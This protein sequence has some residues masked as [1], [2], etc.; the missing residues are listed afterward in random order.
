MSSIITYDG[1]H[2]NNIEDKVIAHCISDIETN[3]VY[4]ND[5]L[6]LLFTKLNNDVINIANIIFTVLV[7]KF[8]SKLSNNFT[9]DAFINGH[10]EINSKMNNLCYYF[11][12]L[13]KENIKCTEQSICRKIKNKLLGE[14]FVNNNVHQFIN[15]NINNASTSQII[16]LH[17]ILNFYQYITVC[18]NN[19]NMNDTKFILEFEKEV[20][21]NHINNINYEINEE[22]TNLLKYY[23]SN[24]EKKINEQINIIRELISVGSDVFN[25]DTFME[26]YNKNLIVRLLSN[27]CNYA[28][29]NELLLSV[30]YHKNFKN[31]SKAKQIIND[32]EES[33]TQ[34]KFFRDQ[35]I[36]KCHSDKY[37]HINIEKLNKNK[38]NFKILNQY[39][40][41]ISQCDPIN[42]VPELSIYN[43]IIANVH[44]LNY[45]DRYTNCLYD[46]ST[47][48]IIMKFRDNSYKLKLNIYQANIL[49]Y[50]KKNPNSTA[51]I[52]SVDMNIDIILL[53]EVLNQLLES[54]IITRTD[55]SDSDLNMK[56]DINHEFYKYCDE[57]EL[58]LTKNTSDIIDW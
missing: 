19:G 39:A 29:E 31:F 2:I 52:L 43:D 30:K 55:D 4:F 1:I 18:Q 22:I 38:I 23:N 46:R 21:D 53:G 49:L 20:E 50:L 35:V 37:Q 9:I 27:N 32:I 45:P 41:N 34:N 57:Y 12:K 3:S 44:K 47:V 58:D 42:L 16:S 24:D 14:F 25:C 28:I 7:E 56:F 26:K 15:K 40:W 13:C 6:T 33:M 36:I 5:L 54:K 48:N 10:N 51:Y 8:S 11:D 17:N